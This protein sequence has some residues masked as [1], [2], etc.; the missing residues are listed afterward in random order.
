MRGVDQQHGPL[1]AQRRCDLIDVDHP[2]VGP[3]HGR[4][5]GKPDGGGTWRFDRGKDGRGPIAV[6]RPAHDVD[7]EPLGRSAGHP[8][9]YRRGMIVLQHQHARTRRHGDEL[10]GGG[11]AVAH[12]GNQRDVIRLGVDQPRRRAS[13]AFKL[14]L[15]KRR[16]D[17][18]RFSLARDAEAARLLRG[19]G[20]RTP[21]GGIEVANLARNIEQRALRGQH[22]TCRASL[23]RREA[24]VARV[25]P[26]AILEARDKHRAGR[27]GSCRD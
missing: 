25:G 13:R 19:D 10:G 17:P 11:H 20:Q 4:D 2:A 9:Q 12:G 3:V 22:R 24:S 6:I 1:P 21:G 5:G 27:L 8:F 26:V 7:A 18:P 16:I 15:W 23:V 14:L